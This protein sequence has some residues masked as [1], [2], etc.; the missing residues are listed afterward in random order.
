VPA[1]SYVDFILKTVASR[2]ALEAVILL[3][4]GLRKFGQKAFLVAPERDDAN[5]SERE[6]RPASAV[7][8]ADLLLNAT[9]PQNTAALPVRSVANIAVD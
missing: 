9:R 2:R 3:F 8:D 4:Q 7:R 5:Q 6:H 1:L